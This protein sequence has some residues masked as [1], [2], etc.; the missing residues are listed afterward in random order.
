[1]LTLQKKIKTRPTIKNNVESC[2]QTSSPL[3]EDI[4]RKVES[5]AGIDN[6]LVLVGEIGVGK[7]SLA[8]I[9]H[10]KSRRAKGPFLSYYCINTN[11]NDYKEAFWEQVHVENEHFLLKYDV[12]EKASNG[13]LYLNKFSELSNDFKLKIIDSYIH[14]CTQLFKYNLAASPRLIISI[15]QDS[16]QQFLK[17]ESWNRL[18]FLLNPVSIILPPLRERHE[19]IR[20]LI[21]SFI[22]EARNTEPTWHR[23]GISD[24]AM[25][26]CIAYRWPG[27]VRQLKNAIFQGALLSSGGM[28]ECQHLPFSMNWNLPY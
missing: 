5:I 25:R 6:H 9:I 12:L 3:M 7:K 20:A 8:H 15:S 13:I 24:E 26:E 17:T 21:S 2:Y 1:M 27:N 23:L 10:K 4:Y 19:D 14:G 16:Y 22:D 11:E 18:L 28:I